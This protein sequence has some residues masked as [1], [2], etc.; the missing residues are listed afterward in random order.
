VELIVIAAV[1]AFGV[2]GTDLLLR[3][4]SGQILER[5]FVRQ[6]PPV[7]TWPDPGTAN[8]DDPDGGQGGGRCPR[9]PDRPKRHAQIDVVQVS[10]V[11]HQLS[12]WPSPAPAG[13]DP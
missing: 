3:W 10:P 9:R 11:E 8:R 7:A 13:D 2:G 5:F 12:P 4:A 1:A 6:R